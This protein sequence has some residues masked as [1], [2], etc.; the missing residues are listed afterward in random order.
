ML[1]VFQVLQSPLKQIEIKHFVI[2]FV[3]GHEE[4]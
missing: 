1:W 4:N 3:E 2:S